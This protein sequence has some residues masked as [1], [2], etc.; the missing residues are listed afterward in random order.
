MLRRAIVLF[1][2]LSVVACGDPDPDLDLDSGRDA[3]S[4]PDAASSPDAGSTTVEFT[5]PAADVVYVDG[6]VRL[7]LVTTG[8]NPDRVEL[9]KDGAL[10]VV[11]PL[12]YTYEWNTSEES[13]GDH[14]IQ[15]RASSGGALVAMAERTFTLDRTAPVLVEALP[16]ADAQTAVATPI[17]LT[18]SE[19][20]DA[21]TVTAANVSFRVGGVDVAHTRVLTEGGTRIEIQPTSS[22][23][24]PAAAR[25]TVAASVT[26]LAGNPLGAAVTHNV[27]YPGWVPLLELRTPDREI[28][29]VEVGGRDLWVLLRDSAGGTLELSRIVGHELAP[30]VPISSY[31]DGT[32]VLRTTSDGRPVVGWYQSDG[33]LHVEE[34]DASGTL[35]ARPSLVGS[36]AFRSFDLEV[37]GDGSPW[38]VGNSDATHVEVRRI[39]GTGWVAVG[40]PLPDG[41]GYF[42]LALDGA[43]AYVA[44]TQAD[45]CVVGTFTA[46]GSTQTTVVAGRPRYVDC[47]QLS[48]T[49]MGSGRIAMFETHYTTPF[50][51]WRGESTT[52]VRLSPTWEPTGGTLPS[53][54]STS[55]TTSTGYLVSALTTLFDD[56]M[57]SWSLE[58]VGALRDVASFGGSPVVVEAQRILRLNTR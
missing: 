47:Q 45:S 30:V 20:L 35:V 23:S 8:P 18:F 9:W 16:P 15:A 13:E 7:Q 42:D 10:F 11:L 26:D 53:W 27:S 28:V 48:L 43:T 55:A 19:P 33:M 49:R 1:S 34:L 31:T 25:V 38:V 40:T 2:S 52:A 4:P 6:T 57:G 37:A 5:L 58:G 22:P 21:A 32:A 44:Y 41:D 54:P 3:A 39:Q 46:A 51:D 56:R 14:V 12:P 50:G 17:T 36:P 24:V 29:E